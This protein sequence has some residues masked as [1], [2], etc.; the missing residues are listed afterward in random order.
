[1]RKEKLVLAKI[2]TRS[3]TKRF[4]DMYL[5]NDDVIISEIKDIFLK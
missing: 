4:I 1:M 3:I 2:Y 5:L